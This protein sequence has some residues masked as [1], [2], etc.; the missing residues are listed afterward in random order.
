MANRKQ[1]AARRLE[2]QDQEQAKE[3]VETPEAKEEHHPSA[4]PPSGKPQ[5]ARKYFLI[6]WGIPLVIFVVIAIIK[7]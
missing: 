6:L 1:R 3:Q 7:G 2:E 5:S 4:S